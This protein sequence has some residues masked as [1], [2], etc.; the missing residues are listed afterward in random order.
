MA[1]IMGY[2]AVYGSR[3][4]VNM[5]RSAL[6]S[7]GKLC[8]VLCICRGG[9]Y[10]VSEASSP[11]CAMMLLPLV[12]FSIVQPFMTSRDTGRGRSLARVAL[13]LEACDSEC[14]WWA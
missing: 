12:V 1:C 11:S 3:A 6:A 10:G 14:A 8:K 9:E 4:V 5:E 13:R 2:L 7:F